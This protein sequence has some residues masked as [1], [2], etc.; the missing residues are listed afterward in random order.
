MSWTQ[1]ENRHGAVPDSFSAGTTEV[2]VYPWR[3]DSGTMVHFVDMPGF[4]D[5]NRSE[6]RGSERDHCVAHQILHRAHTTERHH[7]P[8]PIN[9]CPNAGVTIE[10]LT[11]VQEIVWFDAL[12]NVVL[13]TTMWD[14]VSEQQGEAREHELVSTPE[15]WKEMV[16]R[17]NKLL[18]YAGWSL[19]SKVSCS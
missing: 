18:R 8:P 7:I 15:F 9:G 3:L 2:D 11:H 13:A 12:K 5:T 10:Q 4:D 6:H 16:E 17:G 1:K 14:Q 19:T